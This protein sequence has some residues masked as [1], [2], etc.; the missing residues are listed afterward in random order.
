MFLCD[1]NIISELARRQPNP[2][3]VTWARGVSDVFLSVVTVE[4]IYYGLAWKPNDR[5]ER[6]FENFWRSH[7]QILPVTN[8]I[9]QT[10][11]QLRGHLQQ[12]GKTRSQ[13]DMLIAATAKVHQLTLVTHNIKDFEDCQILLFDPFHYSP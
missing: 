9:A 2:K 3:V 10:S 7:C 4:E 8:A 11:G 6:W 5:I 13:P 1:T 12:Q